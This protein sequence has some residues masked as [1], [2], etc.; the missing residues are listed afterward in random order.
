MVAAAFITQLKTIFN[1]SSIA[2][3]TMEDLTDAVIDELNLNGL[4][5]SNMA[6]SA[7]SKTITLT[8]AQKGAVR[9]IFRVIYSSWY[10]NADNIQAG[11]VGNISLAFADL[12]SQPETQKMIT[13]TAA[14]LKQQTLD[15]PIYIAN[16]TDE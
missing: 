16:A 8:S 12:I 4:S 10:K 2:D 13:Q 7:G 14:L 9:R 3:A 6:G 15:P 11:G 1:D 5:I